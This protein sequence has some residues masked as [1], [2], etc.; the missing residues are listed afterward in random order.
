[1]DVCCRTS[2]AGFLEQ[3]DNLSLLMGFSE[4]LT[5]DLPLQV[6]AVVVPQLRFVYRQS[7]DLRRMVLR[8]DGLVA[9]K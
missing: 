7:R 6:V 2:I 5:D 3:R 9:D 1:M 4:A 8:D